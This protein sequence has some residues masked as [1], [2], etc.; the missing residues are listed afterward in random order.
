MDGKSIPK[1]S[2]GAVENV[3]HIIKRE[4]GK[5]VEKKLENRQKTS[6]FPLFLLT[7]KS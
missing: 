6:Q 3:I 1:N 5:P 4:L 2:E 7:K